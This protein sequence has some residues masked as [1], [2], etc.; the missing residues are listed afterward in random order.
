[1][2][3]LNGEIPMAMDLGT[4]KVVMKRML[5]QQS[6]EHQFLTDLDAEIPMVMAGLTQQM[7]GRPTHTDLPIHS[8]LKRFNGVI[9]MQ[10]VLVMSHLVQCVMIVQKYL[11]PQLEMYRVVKIQMMMGGQMNTANGMPLWPSWAKTQQHLG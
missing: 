10:M 5:V 9:P 6:E 11:E 8:L 3:Q 4:K 7:I 2:N 1:M